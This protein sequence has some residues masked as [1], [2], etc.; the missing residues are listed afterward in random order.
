MAKPETNEELRALIIARQ[1][2]EE[3]FIVTIQPTIG[4]DTYELCFHLDWWKTVCCYRAVPV[5]KK[6]DDWAHGVI[7]DLPLEVELGFKECLYH[8]FGI[9][10][11]F[12]NLGAAQDAAVQKVLR[13]TTV[14]PR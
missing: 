4:P 1:Y 12:F 10:H 5:K 8:L 9:E 11:V 13:L 3:L 14:T 7:D 2:S 6:G